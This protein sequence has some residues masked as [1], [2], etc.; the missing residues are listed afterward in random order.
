MS[1]VAENAKTELQKLNQEETMLT[2]RIANDQARL[3]VIAASK[4]P[5]EKI[6]A[7]EVAA[8]PSA[9]TA[10]TAQAHT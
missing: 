10:A 7:D 8:T 9:S 2:S 5:L 4:S 1:P 3:T 6:I